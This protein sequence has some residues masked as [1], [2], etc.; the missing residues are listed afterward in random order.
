MALAVVVAA[1]SP[2]SPEFAVINF[3]NTPPTVVMTPGFD[4]G[5]VVDC[6]GTLA[7]VAENSG[8]SVALFDISAPA[9]PVQTVGVARFAD[10][11]QQSGKPLRPFGFRLRAAAQHHLQCRASEPDPHQCR[12]SPDRRGQWQQQLCRSLLRRSTRGGRSGPPPVQCVAIRLRWLD[13]G[14]GQRPH[15]PRR[16][17]N[18]RGVR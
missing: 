12:A 10:R 14:S 13:R 18:L 3:G 2:G 15:R 8:Y 16:D 9:S 5:N 4:N 17:L 11:H 1:A 7:A 6:Y